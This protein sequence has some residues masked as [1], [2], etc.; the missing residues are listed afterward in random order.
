MTDDDSAKIIM[1]WWWWWF[2]MDVGEI[3]NLSR[4]T[5]KILRPRTILSSLLVLYST[6]E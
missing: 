1:G 6:I 3:G 5:F 4:A 2:A